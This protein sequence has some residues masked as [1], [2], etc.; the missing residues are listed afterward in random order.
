MTLNIPPQNSN[1]ENFVDA[2]DSSP[3]PNNPEPQNAQSTY[4]PSNDLIDYERERRKLFKVA[5][6]ATLIIIVILY[7]ALG[8]WIFTQNTSYHIHSNMWH[9]AVILAIPPT[10]LLFLL[11]KAVSKQPVEQPNAYPVS[12]FFNQIINIL[13]EWVT[14][15]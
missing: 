3:L 7:I 9:I 4:I 1:S 12:E 14:K 5:F 15:K 2:S 13:K 11:I 6:Y 8:V 10:T